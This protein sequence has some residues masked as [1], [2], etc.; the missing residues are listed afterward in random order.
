V[1]VVVWGIPIPGAD[2]KA[3]LKSPQ[4]AAI[5]FTYS[6]PI[7]RLDQ[8]WSAPAFT[9][10]LARTF[11]IGAD[12][13]PYLYRPVNQNRGL[14]L[15]GP[16]IAIKMANT[17]PYSPTYSTLFTESGLTATLSDGG[18]R[19]PPIINRLFAPSSKPLRLDR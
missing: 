2:L 9:T 3:L 10:A 6:P 1:L 15:L 18:P 7:H 14:P 11:N 8:K 12:L 13:Y 17:F 19:L 5:G 4:S 16:L